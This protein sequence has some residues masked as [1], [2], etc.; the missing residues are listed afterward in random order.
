MVNP[1]L[2]AAFDL[3]LIASA[4]LVIASMVKEYL[5]S[6]VPSIGSPA[7][8]RQAAP[9]VAEHV[10]GNA[11]LQRARVTRRSHRAPARRAVRV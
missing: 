9:R 5:D 4:T 3:F 7:S 6:R 10:A 11:H 1:A 2:T 8:K